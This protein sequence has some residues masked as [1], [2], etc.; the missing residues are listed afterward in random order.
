MNSLTW[1]LF[2]LTP[3][4]QVGVGSGSYLFQFGCMC[5]NDLL[6]LFLPFK[7]WFAEI[8]SSSI[9]IIQI[10]LQGSPCYLTKDASFELAQHITPLLVIQQTCTDPTT[11]QALR[12]LRI[13]SEHCLQL[14]LFVWFTPLPQDFCSE[15][16]TSYLTRLHVLCT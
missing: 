14:C 11:C 3:L 4:E 7:R 9:P 10:P 5:R 1:S 2:G 16:W 15:L 8:M 12:S 6:I 13:F